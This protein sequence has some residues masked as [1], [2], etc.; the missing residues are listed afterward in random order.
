V[1]ELKNAIDYAVAMSNESQ[2]MPEHLPARLRNSEKNSGDG[3]YRQLMP[4]DYREAKSYFEKA[5][6]EEILLRFG[7][8]INLTAKRTGLSKVTLIDKIRRYEIDVHSIKY[9]AHL[10]NNSLAEAI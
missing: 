4:T 5:Y 1:R 8:K 10:K 7:G 2:L 6:L 9:R 3:N